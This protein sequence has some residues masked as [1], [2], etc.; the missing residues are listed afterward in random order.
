MGSFVKD[1]KR[2]KGAFGEQN[3]RPICGFTD[4]LEDAANEEQ[5]V[6]NA[7]V[8]RLTERHE[9]GADIDSESPRQP[10][11]ENHSRGI[12]LIEPLPLGHLG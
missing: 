4:R 8:G 11:A 12:A 9:L 10:K 1:V 3:G 5:L 6:G 7:A 2:P